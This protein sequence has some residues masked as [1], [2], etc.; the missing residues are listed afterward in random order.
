MAAGILFQFVAR[1]LPGRGPE[2]ARGIIAKINV[3]P[4]KIERGIVVSVARNT[5]QAR[6][7][8]KRIAAGGIGDDAEV[9]LAAQVIDPGERRIRLSDYVFAVLIV[10]MPEFHEWGSLSETH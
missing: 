9:S 1:G 2:F 3:A 10:E 6:V 8:V 4:A 5:A 7:A